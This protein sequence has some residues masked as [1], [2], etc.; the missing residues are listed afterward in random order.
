M[1]TFDDAQIVGSGKQ[2]AVTGFANE[3]IVLAMLMSRYPNSSLVDMPLSSYDIIIERE[4]NGRID[5]LR[6]Q[7]KTA[8][9]SISFTGGTR[10]GSDRSYDPATHVNKKYVQDPSKSDVVIGIHRA[11]NT[12]QLFI[13]P[14]LLIPL[15][16]VGSLSTDKALVFSDW[17]MIALCD[18]EDELRDF[19]R[20]KRDEGLYKPTQFHSTFNDWIDSTVI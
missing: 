20:S 3:H 9:K 15:L 4:L 17:A 2:A 14:S 13:V 11:A 7:V 1:I 10:G 16:G 18:N 12:T 5:F 6:A 19:L 8:S